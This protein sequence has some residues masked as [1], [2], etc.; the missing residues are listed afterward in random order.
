MQ[1]MLPARLGGVEADYRTMMEL[2]ALISR[3]CGSTG[4][5]Y[6]NLLSCTLILALW[7]K[8]AQDEIWDADRDALLTGNLI[9]PAARRSGPTA[10]TG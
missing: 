7:P 10:A 8:R 2:V 9:F 4:W 1:A 5:V 3:G 6:C